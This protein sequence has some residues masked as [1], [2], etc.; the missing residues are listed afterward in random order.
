M[1]RMIRSRP[2]MNLQE[3]VHSYPYSVYAGAYRTIEKA[4]AALSAYREKN[5][6]P[7]WVKVDLRKGT[8][9]RVFLGFFRG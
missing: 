4:E 6:N 3:K 1:R 8:W 2:G 5:L 7:Y 9:F